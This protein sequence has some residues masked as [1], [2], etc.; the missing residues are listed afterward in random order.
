MLTKELGTPGLQNCFI[1][2]SQTIFVNVDS[3]AKKPSTSGKD[4]KFEDV[5]AGSSGSDKG[6][7]KGDDLPPTAEEF[8]DEEEEDEKKGKG[9][10]SEGDDSKEDDDSDELAKGTVTNISR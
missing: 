9:S 3:K 6:S 8:E 1:N 2:S 7:G 5:D 4:E 10:G